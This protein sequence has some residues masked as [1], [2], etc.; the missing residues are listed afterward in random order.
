MSSR[1]RASHLAL[2]PAQPPAPAPSRHQPAARHAL[3]M[4]E[5]LVR[6]LAGHDDA[7]LRLIVAPA[8]YGKTTALEQ[9]AQRDERPFAWL[10]AGHA[11]GS[12]ARLLADAACALDAIEPPFVLVLEQVE[13]LERRELLDALTALS[14]LLAPGCVL[15]LASRREPALRLGR[16]R[17]HGEIV[18]L[19]AGELAMTRG[20]GRAMLRALGLQLDPEQADL[21][22]ERTEGWPAGLSLA[23]LA[24]REQDDLPAA[25]ACFGGADRLVVDYLRDEMLAQL[26]PAHVRF[27]M[28][29]SLLEKLSGALCDAALGTHGSGALL[30]GLAR[31]N[32]LLSALDR[33]EEHFRCNPLLAD[34]L[35]AELR[36]LEPEREAEV[37]R[38]AS[39]AYV[40]QGDVER[41]I[42]HAI[43]AD[44]T[45][46][47]GRRIWRVVPAY[48]ASGRTATLERWLGRFAENRIAQQPELALAAAAVH[49]VAGNRDLVERWALIAGARLAAA[50]AGERRADLEAGVAIM[51]AVVA[52]DG[53]ATM[54]DDAARAYALEPEDSAWRALCCLLVGAAAVLSGDRGAGVRWLEEGSRRGARGAPGIQVLC[55]ALLGLVALTEERWADGAG[56]AEL[57]RAQVE[58]VGLRDDAACA[59][60]FAVSALARAHRGRHAAARADMRDA[61]RLL[62]A[63]HGF[64]PFFAGAATVALARAELR[65]GDVPGARALLA[66]CERAVRETPD[67]PTLRAWLDAARIR[68]D[69]LANEVG[70]G[71]SALTCAELRVLT[72]LP[73]HLPFRQIAAELHVSA[74]TVKTQANAVYRK[75][76]ASSRSEAVARATRLGLLGA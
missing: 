20:E 51:R 33:S 47:A 28:R 46:L 50:P 48:A 54:R 6:A 4:R 37:H 61:R 49:M 3:I 8:G 10:T 58:R 16:M 24:L 27:L 5:R 40:A 45:A 1:R 65:L 29:A 67:A 43:A 18:E 12:P 71:P 72:F 19:R 36:R 57:A 63:L 21:L 68:A 56:L 69:A 53:I 15:A 41:A 60:V 32:L 74:N 59:L 35:R 39:D 64:T 76:D 9:W 34:A 30:R 23:A 14:A 17:T 44:D 42:E 75:L 55:L 2:A 52:R 13:V 31:S 70:A 26:P 25:I 11:H 73:T 62:V 22:V 38:R 7:P 66:E